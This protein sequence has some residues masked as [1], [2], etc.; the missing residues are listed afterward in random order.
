MIITLKL[1]CR[2]ILLY[3]THTLIKNLTYNNQNLLSINKGD[4]SKRS[5]KNFFVN[6]THSFYQNNQFREL[7]KMPGFS[8]IEKNLQDTPQQHNIDKFN[9]K[10]RYKASAS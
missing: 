10:Y 4:N 5:D 9:E 1:S 7:A 2:I 3:N 6:K 8:Q